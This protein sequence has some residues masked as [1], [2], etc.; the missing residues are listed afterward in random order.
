LQKRLDSM[1]I[2]LICPIYWYLKWI[3]SR[4][5]TTA[6]WCPN[7]AIITWFS[8]EAERY[9]CKAPSRHWRVV[10]ENSRISSMV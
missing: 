9:I 5:C 6:R 7:K 8:W 2:L 3:R 10:T 4:R 1:I